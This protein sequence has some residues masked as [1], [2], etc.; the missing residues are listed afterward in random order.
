MHIL[1]SLVS[2]AYWIAARAVKLL[3]D[4][5][6]NLIDPPFNTAQLRDIVYTH[7]ELKDR[8]AGNIVMVKI[9]R[10]KDLVEY[11]VLLR[12]NCLSF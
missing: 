1:Q 2:T 6:D 12:N 11:L 8:Y 7:F 4:E 10:S 3:F 5:D 9:L